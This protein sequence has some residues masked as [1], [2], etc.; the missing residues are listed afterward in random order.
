M[1]VMS[2]TASIVRRRMETIPTAM[3][4]PVSAR[5]RSRFLRENPISQSDNLFLLRQSPLQGLG[6]EDEGSFHCNPLSRG[7]AREDVCPFIR[8]PSSLHLAALECPGSGNHK[9]LFMPVQVHHG[10]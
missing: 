1:V 6:L 10:A 3:R 8:G 9:N 7:Q 2:G 4:M 5:T